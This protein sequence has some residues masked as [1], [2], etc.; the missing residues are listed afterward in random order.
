MAFGRPEGHGPMGVDRNVPSYEDYAEAI[1]TA[2]AMVHL[3]RRI[4]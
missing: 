3:L 1:T 4:K 2:L